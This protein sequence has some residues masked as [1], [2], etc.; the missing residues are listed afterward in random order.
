MAF[1]IGTRAVLLGARRNVVGLKFNSTQ[2]QAQG[3]KTVS[4]HVS[5]SSFSLV[6]H[7]LYAISVPPAEYFLQ[8][9]C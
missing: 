2:A 5:S 1:N 8:N 3:Q 6:L 7:S 4:P 9:G